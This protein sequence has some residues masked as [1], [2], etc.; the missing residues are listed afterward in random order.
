[1]IRSASPH[2]KDLDAASRCLIAVLGGRE[3][4]AQHWE[5]DAVYWLA[6]HTAHWAN[7]VLN[8]ESQ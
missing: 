3:R 6:R 2:L 7:L 8:W 4:W 1:M 5:A